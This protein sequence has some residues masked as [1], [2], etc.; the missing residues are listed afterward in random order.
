MVQV[1]G[2]LVALLLFVGFLYAAKAAAAAAKYRDL[3]TRRS[4][5]IDESSGSTTSS[6]R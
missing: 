4:H 2:N 3:E 5:R 1:Q 6:E